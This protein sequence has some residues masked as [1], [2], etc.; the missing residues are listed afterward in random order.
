MYRKPVSLCLSLVLAALAV[1]GSAEAQGSIGERGELQELRDRAAIHE[2]LLAYGRTIDQR[3][4]DAFGA[5]FTA[6]GEYGRSKGPDA[7]A[8]GMRRTF[9]TNPL[10]FREPNFHVFF[11]QTIA[12]EGMHATAQSMSFYVVPDEVGGFRIALMAAYDDRLVK[13]GGAWKFQRRTVKGLTPE[14]KR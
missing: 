3:D 8:A 6:D 9:A 12:V 4:F 5:L 11:N 13:T 1:P 2:L 10:G 14:P 7:I